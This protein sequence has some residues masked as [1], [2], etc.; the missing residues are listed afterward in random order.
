MPQADVLVNAAVTPSVARTATLE[1]ADLAATSHGPRRRSAY[2]AP[3]QPPPADAELVEQPLAAWIHK[4][5]MPARR[6]RPGE[7]LVIDVVT[8]HDTRLNPRPQRKSP[9]DG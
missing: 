4:L 7:S 9:E 6:P 5:S 2:R 3:A 8:R 1:L